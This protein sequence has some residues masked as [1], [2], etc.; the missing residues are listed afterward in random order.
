M[1]QSTWS[2]TLPRVLEIDLPGLAAVRAAPLTSG[3]G[4]PPPTTCGGVS[5]FL[6]RRHEL[7]HPHS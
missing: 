1:R 3:V 6:T 2:D 7:P 4:A 5:R